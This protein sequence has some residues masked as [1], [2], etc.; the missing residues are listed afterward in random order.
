MGEPLQLRHMLAYL[1]L[2]T[3]HV[4]LSDKKGSYRAPL[5]CWLYFVAIDRL[6]NVTHASVEPLT[7]GHKQ[8]GTSHPD[9][10]SRHT[11]A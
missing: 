10:F 7:K 6:Q 5:I 4:V 1:P 2:N 11:A 9:S 3:L 8:I